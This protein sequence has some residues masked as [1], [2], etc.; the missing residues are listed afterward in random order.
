MYN[1]YFLIGY[2]NYYNRKLRRKLT[3]NEYKT[4]VDNR[5]IRLE[6][7]LNFNP[8]DGV[9]TEHILNDLSNYN[10]LA[11]VPDYMIVCDEDD[12]VLQR[13]FVIDCNRTR[14]GQYKCLLHRDVLAESYDAWKTCDVFVEKATLDP[15]DSAIFNRENMTYSEIKNK[16]DI[17]LKDATGIPWL[18][19]YGNFKT[20]EDK[21]IRFGT[22][23]RETTPNLI[24][25]T[26][27]QEWEYYRYSQTQNVVEAQE[28]R[29]VRIFTINNND[30]TGIRF[31]YNRDPLYINRSQNDGWY[32]TYRN[33][34]PEN[35]WTDE[36]LYNDDT[37]PTFEESFMN[38]QGRTLLG[39]FNSNRRTFL[40]R[41]IQVDRSSNLTEVNNVKAQDG[42]IIKDS[43]NKIYRVTL[44]S[45]TSDSSFV[46][47]TNSE[48]VNLDSVIRGVDGITLT[49]WSSK[50]ITLSYRATYYT[51]Q[52]DAVDT[53]SSHVDFTD[54]HE[55]SDAPYS[56]FF[57]PY[58]DFIAKVNNTEIPQNKS[59]S[60]NFF[61]SI[62]QALGGAGFTY[63]LQ[64]LPYCP[65]QSYGPNGIIKTN[66]F[67]KLMIDCNLINYRYV[68]DEA[69]NIVD[70]IYIADQS[71]ASFTIQDSSYTDDFIIDPLTKKV[72][73]ETT[74]YRLNS[75]SGNS[76]FQFSP[77]LNDGI[78]EFQVQFTYKPFAPYIHIAPKFKSM[79]GINQPEDQRGLICSG[80]FSITQTND[81]WQTYELQNINYQ[82]IFHREIESLELQQDVARM[83]DKWGGGTAALSGAGAGAAMGSV[84][85]PWGAVAGAAVGGVVS[86][87][88]AIADYNTNEQ[89]RNDALDLKKDMFEYHKA[90]IKARPN[91]IASISGFTIN[92]RY[93]PYIEFFESTPGERKALIKKITHNG[94]T[95]MRIDTPQ[96]FFNNK[97]YIAGGNYN[98]DNYF[99]GQLVQ[100]YLPGEDFHYINA[101]A[102][103]LNKGVY[104]PVGGV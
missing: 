49:H 52:I 82:N 87:I 94:M 44:K 59:N 30:S 51:L 15:S 98:L 9:N 24:I 14:G 41:A 102:D 68:F 17:E 90:T 8:A 36:E 66:R 103:E 95:V 91:T 92:S 13:W 25:N 84:A 42:M 40:D 63:D 12:D 61:T 26:P 67:G 55:L 7:C 56:M 79:Y 4:A 70:V 74:F 20:L 43:M 104:I 5:Y 89:L 38:H 22:V 97:F 69:D 75:P 81:Q 45:R 31:S 78:E 1:L 39:N 96:N 85:G 60:M 2:N 19:G 37:R 101:I 83:A 33:V 65:I 58:G 23:G 46:E 88:G 72:D 27:I 76:T 10:V 47:P 100:C 6:G 71:S 64:L 48:W 18:V 99:K 11:E 50:A 53:I 73:Y 77:E 86:G 62:A 29:E 3:I 35:R 54:V 80:N 21:V 34:A 16:R 93:F 28:F 32:S 57:M